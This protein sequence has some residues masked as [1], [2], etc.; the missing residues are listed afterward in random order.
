MGDVLNDG[1]DSTG[2]TVPAD[3]AAQLLGFWFDGHG[4][5]DWFGGGAAFDDAVRARFA[6]WHTALRSLPPAHFLTDAATA[7]A[8]IILFDQV[9]R[10]IHRHHADAFA[11]DAL[12]LAIAREAEARSWDAGLTPEQA[13]FVYL[14]FEHSEDLA[15]QR[16]SLKLMTPLGGAFADY[17]RAHFAMIE[18]FGRFPHRN[19]A[20]GRA[21]REGEAEA[22]AAGNNW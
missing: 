13:S 11:T 14:P 21:N 4:M 22:V 9:P 1:V 2:I 8:A 15:D 10:N 16:E 6:D 5:S 17:A 7:R 12:A 18:R 20:L 3:W 19:A